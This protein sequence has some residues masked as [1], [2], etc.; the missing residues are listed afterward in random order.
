MPGVLITLLAVLTPLLQLKVT[1][2]TVDDA[3]NVSFVFA[4]VKTVGGA[5]LTSGGV[6]F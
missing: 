2:A 6:I 1:P 3:A 5:M 4:Q